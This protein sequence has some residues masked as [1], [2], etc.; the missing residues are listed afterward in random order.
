MVSYMCKL[1]E[2]RLVMSRRL[3]VSVIPQSREKGADAE[4]MGDTEPSL[5]VWREN[6][7]PT[8]IRAKTL[9]WRAI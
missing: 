8:V 7:R 9:W 5:L 3:L 2:V 6:I 4:V 1:I